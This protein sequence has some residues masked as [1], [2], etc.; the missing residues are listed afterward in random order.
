MMPLFQYE[1]KLHIYI[2]E[3]AQKHYVV[4]YLSYI[5]LEAATVCKQTR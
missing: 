4:T 2:Y 5:N 1:Y 3:D